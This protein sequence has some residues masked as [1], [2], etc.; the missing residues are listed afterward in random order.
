MPLQILLIAA[1]S[2]LSLWHGIVYESQVLRFCV[3]EREAA[4]PAETEESDEL[5]PWAASSG[6]A[7]EIGRVVEGRFREARLPHILGSWSDYTEGIRA[8]LAHHHS[9]ATEEGP[10]AVTRLRACR[11]GHVLP[12]FLRVGLEEL[13]GTLDPPGRNALDHDAVLPPG[14]QP[15]LRHAAHDHAQL[16]GDLVL[17]IGRQ[18]AECGDTSV[19]CLSSASPANS[20]RTYSK[21]CHTTSNTSRHSS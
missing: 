13:P 11:Y 19:K 8:H 3:R 15:L 20:F 14:L 21:S 10:N 18:P 16:A 4:A 5:K 17:P 12:R 9:D 7:K 1:G 2:Y 6:F